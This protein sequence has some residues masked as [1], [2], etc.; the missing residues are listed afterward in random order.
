MSISVLLTGAAGR[1]G[2]YLTPAFAA[3]YQLRTFDRVPVDGSPDAVTGDLTDAEAVR[4]A[5]DGVEV[6]VHL[7]AQPDEAPMD[8]LL[9]P[10][11]VGLHHVLEAAHQSPTV[12]R[13]VFASTVQTVDGT[14]RELNGISPL[15]VPRPNSKYGATKVFGEALGRWYHDKHGLEFIALR[16]GA[17]QPYENAERFKSHEYIAA[18]WLSPRDTVQLFQKAIEVPDAKWGVVFATSRT[19]RLRLDIGPTYDLLGYEPQDNAEEW[20]R[21]AQEGRAYLPGG[22]K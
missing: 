17:F 14:P 16:L 1:I 18:I 13:V 4:N 7:A 2:R 21:A 10:N 8:V 15:D 11:I 19:T 5:M 22:Q 9:G 12:R 20:M 6:V 3:R